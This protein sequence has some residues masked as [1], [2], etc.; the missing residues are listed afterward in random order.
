ME[1][2]LVDPILDPEWDHLVESHSS[3]TLF[4]RGCWA[5]VLSWTY[6]HTPLYLRFC[7][8]GSV[9]G[10]LPMMEVRSAFTGRRGVCLPFT[11]ICEPLFFGEC[12]SEFVADIL[13]KLATERRWDHFE[14]RHGNIAPASPDG[15]ATFRGHRL[16]L[17]GGLDAVFARFDS[18]V[19]QAIR[20]AAR[21]GVSSSIL[22]T[23]EAVLQF[24]RLHVQTRKRH[25]VP[26]QPL[27]FFLK[28][29]R[30]IIQPGFGFVAVAVLEARTIAANIF[31]SSGRNAIYKYG[32]SD[33][34]SQSARPSNLAMWAGIRRLVDMGCT[35]LHFG[36]TSLHND[37]LRRFKAGWGAFEHPI[38][39]SKFDVI[40]GAWIG[41]HDRASG[42]YNTFFRGLPSS[43]NRLAGAILY[44]HLD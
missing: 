4:H 15:V 33:G 41:S 28:I 30:E 12:G 6:G 26:P 20:K 16:D 23:E 11:D 7:D 25:G 38:E 37:G 10:L 13:M 36:R 19:R 21:L 3:A 43:L 40:S 9:V 18:S 2:A 29:H 44:P 8:G 35:T 24:Y 5:N 39:Y 32:A 17:S 34:G 1:T 27:S 42:S 31:F 22:Q 14:V